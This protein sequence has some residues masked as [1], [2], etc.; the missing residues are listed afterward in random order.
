MTIA[1]LPQH[2]SA[3]SVAEL[4]PAP[5]RAL[6]AGDDRDDRDDLLDELARL[7]AELA[8]ARG[9]DSPPASPEQLR[10]LADLLRNGVSKRDA[11]AMIGYLKGW[12]GWSKAQQSLALQRCAAV[13]PQ[14]ALDALPARAGGGAR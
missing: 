3:Q 6:V 12:S 2:P 8:R 5:S 10:F 1:T 9:D 11:A 13:R 14:E 4:L 7:R